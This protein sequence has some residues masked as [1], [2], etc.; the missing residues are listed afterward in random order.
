[1]PI[2]QGK[3]I[4]FNI[5][6]LRSEANEIKRF[7]FWIQRFPQKQIAFLSPL[8]PETF[9]SICFF[10]GI[11]VT[12]AQYFRFQDQRCAF[13]GISDGRTV[14]PYLCSDLIV[15]WIYFIRC[16]LDEERMKN[17]QLYLVHLRLTSLSQSHF[18]SRCT[19]AYPLLFHFLISFLPL[20][21]PSHSLTVVWKILAFH[22]TLDLS[23]CNAS[24]WPSWRPLFLEGDTT[25]PTFISCY[26]TTEI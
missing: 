13:R 6:L 9:E 4:I 24:F 19:D 11:W 8:W 18:R 16:S 26:Y 15:R 10:K 20:S 12:A 25:T 1:M 7:R 17:S 3:Y 5:F 22:T 21:L 2:E 14:K 23:I